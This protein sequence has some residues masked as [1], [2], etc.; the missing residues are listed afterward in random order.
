MKL[1]SAVEFLSTYSFL[2]LILAA[3]ISIFLIISTSTTNFFPEQCA[4]ASGLYCHFASVYS[5][6]TYA[7]STLQLVLS[8]SESTPINITGAKITVNGVLSNGDCNPTLVFP[9]QGT[10]C[11]FLLPRAEPIG[12]YVQGSYTISAKYCNSGLN[13]LSMQE[14]SFEPGVYSGS[15]ATSS[16][17]ARVTAFAVI[18]LQAPDSVQFIPYNAAPI[19]PSNFT[20]IQNGQFA[21][22][23]AVSQL[24]YSYGTQSYQ[25]QS[26]Y[27]YPTTGFPASLS[28]LNNNNIACTSPYNSLLTLAS[29]ELYLPVPGHI[30][31]NATSKDAIEL[32]YS[33]EGS[34]TWNSIFNGAAWSI[35]GSPQKYTYANTLQQGFYKFSVEWMSACGGGVQAIQITG[36]K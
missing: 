20:V 10:V 25:G 17:N 28:D 30:V 34:N 24:T 9:G 15:F 18:A 6:S 5:S 7:Y 12:Y 14:C 4:G 11:L 1:Q 22:S 26:Y 16:E 31:F 23:N 13:E 36:L 27:G 2:F 8:D 35:V 33:A 19:I 3:A 21:V 29:T 32:Y